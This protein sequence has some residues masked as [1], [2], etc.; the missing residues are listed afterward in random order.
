MLSKQ[1]LSPPCHS[2][3]TGLSRTSAC[4]LLR[5]L[6]LGSAQWLKGLSSPAPPSICVHMSDLLLT[7]TKTAK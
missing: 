6:D 2:L 4:P 3:H 7:K 1:L 5:D